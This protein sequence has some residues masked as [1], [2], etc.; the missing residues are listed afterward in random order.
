MG[1]TKDIDIQ[2]QFDFKLEVLNASNGYVFE[3]SPF[4]IKITPQRVV[5]GTTYKY[6]YKI[7][8][9]DSSFETLSPSSPIPVDESY[10]IESLET[11]LNFIPKKIGTNVIL[12]SVEDN[13]GN[14]K[15]EKVSYKADYAPFVFLLTPNLSSYTINS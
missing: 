13:H 8:E 15:T 14:I 6:S 10:T 3:T 1:C 5:Q 9:G 12:I 4:N 11:V 7:L 2:D